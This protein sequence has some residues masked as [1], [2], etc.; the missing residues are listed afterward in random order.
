MRPVLPSIRRWLTPRRRDVAVEAFGDRGWT[1]AETGGESDRRE[2]VLTTFNIW[3]DA[4]FADER[5]HAIS[6][7]VVRHEPDIMVFQE[8]TPRAHDILLSHPWVRRHCLCAAVT[9]GGAG[10]YGM[11]LLSRVPL[12][13][14]TYIQLS[15]RM[16][17]GFLC[18]DVV[19]AGVP[20]TVC[21]VHLDSGK[22]SAGLRARQ[23]RDVFDALGT[24]DDAVVLGDFNM[25]DAENARITAP[26]TD[27]WPLL[28]PDEPGYTEDTSVNLM[29][30]D[31]TNKDRH[32]RFD[33]VLVKGSAWRP[34][35]I[36]LLGTQPIAQSHPRIFP[37]DHFGLLCRLVSDG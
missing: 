11:L 2:L 30:L 4:H 25:R 3:N 27:V 6:E 26:F 28:R 17:R 32:V 29:R 20:T 36:D 34:T 14:V 22:A 12:R 5:H 19:A 16:L 9:G 33:R 7:V 18:A 10:D 15:S 1:R 31:S 24:V 23:L 8:V 13:G 35:A 37:S 21:S